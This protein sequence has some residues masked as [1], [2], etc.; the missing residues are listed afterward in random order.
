MELH[1]LLRVVTVMGIVL[2]A[3]A[4]GAQEEPK[5]G[6]VPAATLVPAKAVEDTEEGVALFDV[7]KEL[8]AARE[9]L[10]PLRRNAPYQEG[11]P[12]ELSGGRTVLGFT[13]LAN[14]EL[15]VISGKAQEYG[16][17]AA[18]A[19]IFTKPS[20]NE[21]LWL[22]AQGE[23]IRTVEL[24]F[25]PAAVNA[26]PDGTLYVV[27]AGKIA[28][29]AADGSHLATA[30]SPHVA[31]LIKDRARF[32]QDIRTRREQ[33]LTSLRESIT[34]TEENIKVLQEKPEDQRTQDEKNE[35]AMYQESANS[36]RTYIAQQERQ[37]MEAYIEANLATLREVYRVAASDDELFVVARQAG[38]YGFTIWRMNRD[39]TDAKQIIEGLAGCCGQM[40]VQIHDGVLFVAENAQH[41]V[42]QYDRDGKQLLTFGRANR[43]DVLAGFGGCCNPMNT[44]FTAQG[45]VLTSE[46]NGVV[47]RFR[48]DGQFVEIVGIA[49]IDDG[50][51]NS[52]IAVSSDGS[53]L[54]YL[55]VHKGRLL[56]LSGR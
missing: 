43:A 22:D 14:N 34:S 15:A 17:F 23:I 21:L 2:G 45:D 52:S 27:G 32:E 30:D 35:L 12:L 40:D 4:S 51:K 29:F 46:S 7:V 25:R 10:E 36:L 41:R 9:A 16:A 48:K 50:C 42:G 26:A 38:G 1:K 3:Q 18:I 49:K 8:Q 20:N 37:S 47:K 53:R 55:D 54:Y 5:E 13:A 6:A 44:C 31:E 11:E 56:V 28:S 24:P 39:L 33:E 19:G